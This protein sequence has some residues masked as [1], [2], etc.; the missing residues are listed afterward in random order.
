MEAV[1]TIPSS[2][3]EFRVQGHERVRLQ[4]A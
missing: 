3:R 4:A 2:L 1:A